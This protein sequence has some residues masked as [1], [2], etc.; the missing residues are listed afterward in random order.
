MSGH[1]I[2]HH[3][4]NRILECG[5]CFTVNQFLEIVCNPDKMNALPTIPTAEYGQCKRCKGSANG[6]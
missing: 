1:T 3:P 5:G 6:R 4:H 2:I